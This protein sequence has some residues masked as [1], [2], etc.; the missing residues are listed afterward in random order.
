MIPALPEKLKVLAEAGTGI[1]IFPLGV[2]RTG[3][4]QKGHG[5]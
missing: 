3:G 2:S 5:I 4:H 1:S